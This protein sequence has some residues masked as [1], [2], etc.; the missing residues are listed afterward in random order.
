MQGLGADGNGSLLTRQAAHKS[1]LLLCKSDYSAKECILMALVGSA[2]WPPGNWSASPRLL[3][4]HGGLWRLECGGTGLG[5]GSVVRTGVLRCLEL[6]KYIYVFPSPLLL[7]LL[8][9]LLYHSALGQAPSCV[10]AVQALS[11]SLLFDVTFGT[12][13]NTPDLITCH[14][15]FTHHLTLFQSPC[16]TSSERLRSANS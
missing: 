2:C 6:S 5:G 11:V 14:I 7:L 8:L 3:C 13:I 4:M 9:R 10:P 16:R 1:V 12:S 15:H